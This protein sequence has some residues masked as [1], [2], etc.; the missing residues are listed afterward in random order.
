M[1]SYLVEI[2]YHLIQ[3]QFSVY[4]LNVP[5]NEIKLLIVAYF[6]VAKSL[7][8]E[9]YKK[10]AHTGWTSFQKHRVQPRNA[11]LF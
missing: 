7:H 3:L 9:Q 10:V 8:N 1:A 2:M 5:T 6:L 11:Y 4:W